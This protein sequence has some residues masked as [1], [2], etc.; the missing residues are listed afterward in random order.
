MGK[1][2]GSLL[3][4]SPSVTA[5]PERERTPSSAAGCATPWCSEMTAEGLPWL[6]CGSQQ[7]L[8]REGGHVKWMHG[9]V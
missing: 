8:G 7:L 3:N 1:R 5:S 9:K 2:Q 6:S 4:S